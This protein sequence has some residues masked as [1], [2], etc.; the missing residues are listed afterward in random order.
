MKTIALANDKERALLLE[1]LSRHAV[2]VRECIDACERDVPG[3]PPTTSD[4]LAA[5]REDLAT[6]DRLYARIQAGGLS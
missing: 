2:H 5:Y 1:A 6:I 3:L 4:V